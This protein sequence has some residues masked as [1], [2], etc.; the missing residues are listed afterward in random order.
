MQYTNTI[1]DVFS[2]PCERDYNVAILCLS[3]ISVVHVEPPVVK[4][5]KAASAG[6][7]LV[8]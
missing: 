1:D 5:K 4:M 8:C 3:A 6:H 2:V 7:K